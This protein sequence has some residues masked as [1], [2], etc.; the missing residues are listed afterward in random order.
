M[1]M[2]ISKYKFEGPFTSTEKLKDESGVYIIHCMKDDNYKRIDVGESEEVKTRVENHD[3][4]DCWE[5]E[6]KET[7][8][9]SAY[10]CD[11]KTRE[12]IEQE[13]RSEFELP[14]GEK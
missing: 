6:C 10:Y 12:N 5:K 4:K 14:C 11:E 2:T 9:Y 3:R 13:L 7:I 1:T 8:T